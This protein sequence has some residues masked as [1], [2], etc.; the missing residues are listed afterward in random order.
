MNPV[1]L[2]KLLLLGLLLFFVFFLINIYPSTSQNAFCL[3]TTQSDN[4]RNCLDRNILFVS[5]KIANNFFAQLEQLAGF[6]ADWLN[7]GVLVI[8][9]CC[10]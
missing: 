1:T 10:E 9:A 5:N 2:V 6:L 3:C 8:L 7:V 4:Y